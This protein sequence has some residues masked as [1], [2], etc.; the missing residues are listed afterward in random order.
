[1]RAWSIV[2]QGETP[3]SLPTHWPSVAIEYVVVSIV[4]FLVRGSGARTPGQRFDLSVP[5]CGADQ[6]HA[7]IDGQ[8][9]AG[10]VLRER[11]CEEDGGLAD[12][13][14]AAVALQR[15][16]G[17]R[18]GSGAVADQAL[19]ALGAGDLARHDAACT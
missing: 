16:R 15:Q 1:M 19:H 4:R 5:Q 2:S 7:A 12:V 8:H 11:R 17:N 18:L 9:R 13:V 3:S 14:D 6:R 10:D